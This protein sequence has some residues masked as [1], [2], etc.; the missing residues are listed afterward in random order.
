MEIKVQW[1]LKL[2]RVLSGVTSMRFQERAGRGHRVRRDTGCMGSGGGA[3]GHVGSE[4]G[5]GERQ[6]CYPCHELLNP[7]LLMAELLL[8][9][10]R[11]LPRPSC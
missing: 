7:Y 1:N 6:Q 8:L 9:P 2:R 10:P 4:S 3:V 11:T 5:A